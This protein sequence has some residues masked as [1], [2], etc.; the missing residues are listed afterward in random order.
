MQLVLLPVKKDMKKLTKALLEV[1]HIE[2]LSKNCSI[3]HQLHP[4]LKII[5]V[6]IFI[7]CILSASYMNLIELCIYF[8]LI[9]IIIKIS[10]LPIRSILL[11]TLIA[12][13]FSLCIGLSNLILMKDVVNFYGFTITTGILFFLSIMIKTT[14]TLSLVFILIASSGFDAIA[15]ELVHIKIPAIFVLQLLMTYRYIFLLVEEASQMSKAY[16]LR[17]PGK[18]GIEIKDMGSFLGSLLIR[19]FHR[20]QDVYKC[21]LTRG[22][23][24]DAVYTHYQYFE[25]ENYFLLL[26][27]IGFFMII[28]VVFI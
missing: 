18:K 26:M 13:P 23:K 25:I 8:I 20:S 17:N 11:R 9:L 2:Q 28:K 7:I 24:I 10:Q 19:S 21:M 1:N 16:L 14:L 12:L 22:F 6:M 15:C 4:L 5:T 27:I 3:I